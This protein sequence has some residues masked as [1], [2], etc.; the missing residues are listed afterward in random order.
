MLKMGLGKLPM[1]M[2]M[3]LYPI[4]SK[5]HLLLVKMKAVPEDEI[6]LLATI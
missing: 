3:L 4:F 1:P 2:P 6:C 5:G